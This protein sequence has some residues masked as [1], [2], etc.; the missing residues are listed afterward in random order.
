[1]LQQ[2]IYAAVMVFSLMVFLPVV[3]MK[4]TGSRK[5]AVSAFASALVYG[6]A[7]YLT[8]FCGTPDTVMITKALGFSALAVMS[9][10]YL[11]ALA[12]AGNVSFARPIKLFFGA[13]TAL[14]TVVFATMRIH[15]MCLTGVTAEGPDKDG[16]YAVSF[17]CGILLYV[18]FALIMLA[19][20]AGTIKVIAEMSAKPVKAPGSLKFLAVISVILLIGIT[21]GELIGNIANMALITPVCVAAGELL[22]LI[23]TKGIDNSD[24]IE[25]GKSC[26]I[27]STNDG[28]VILDKNMK[29]LFA[30]KTAKRLFIEFSESDPRKLA[31]IISTI[32]GKDNIKRG[33]RTYSFTSTK[34]TDYSGDCDCNIIM[35]NDVTE[36]ALRDN[37]LSEEAAVD[38]IT[39]LHSRSSVIDILTDTCEETSGILINISFDGFKSLNNL[40]G[41]EEANKLLATFGSIL[42]NNTNSDDVR[43]R[44]GGEVFTIFFKNCSSESVVAHFTMRIEEQITDAVHKQFGDSV[45]VPI[46]VS[47]GGVHVPEAGREYEKLSEIAAKEL[48]KIKS[49]GG[50]GY[51]IY[52][53]EEEKNTQ[54]L[55]FNESDVSL[56]L[57]ESDQ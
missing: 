3:F 53:S 2:I 34:F 1:M 15:G 49:S 22:L 51:S 40:Y 57:N 54:S 24:M 20:T 45:D 55:M 21:A 36:Q 30:N 32:T 17:G 29:F 12:E 42:K 7:G 41:H 44:L 5:W 43:G 46:G 27:D 25:F 48:K 14:V 13:L 37:R 11:F 18:A 26:G 35:I 16:I 4:T 31:E 33:D 52:G 8:L 38:S 19:V 23:I 56:T 9:V 39:G 6:A 10:S 50:H 47:V 28:V